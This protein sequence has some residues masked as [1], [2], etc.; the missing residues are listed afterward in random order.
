MGLLLQFCCKLNNLP[1]MIQR[2]QSVFLLLLALSMLAILALTIWEEGNAQAGQHVE[3]TAFHL[4]ETATA[5]ETASNTIL[6][7]ILAVA[8]AA[9]A[10]YE[11][12]QFK[13]R[14]TQMKLG[15]LN[16]LLIAGTLISVVYYAYYVGE[17]I[18]AATEGEREAGFYIPFAAL[19]LNALANR[20]I[21]RD[22]NLVRS[23]DR[24][25]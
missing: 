3:L 9:V 8:S 24:L 5:G 20:F 21:R 11:I 22:E 12:F 25:R 18:I 17:P 1:I 19:I 10:V 14:L 7:A 13:N 23:V 4:K 6:I 2:I 16:T 15:M